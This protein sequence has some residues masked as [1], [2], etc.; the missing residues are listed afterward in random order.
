MTFKIAGIAAFPIGSYNKTHLMIPLDRVQYLLRMD[1]SV[2]EILVKLN[3]PREAAS[4][5][6][7]LN[8]EFK[9]SGNTE[10]EVQ[11][12]KNISIIYGFMS[13][14]QVIYGFI[15]LIFFLL[16]STVLINTTM[17]VIFERMREIG[18]IAAMGMTGKE[19]VR[20]FFYEAVFLSIVGAF[21]GLIVGVGITLPLSAYGLDF[22]AAMQGIDIEIS[23]IIYPRLN[24]FSTIFVFFYAVVVSS[25]ASLIPSTRA[26]KIQ[27]V[28]ALRYTG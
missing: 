1:K 17:M 13:M 22:G 27:P 16:A 11:S 9:T 23:D 14:A 5:A 19:I 3:N 26:A 2:T 8:R 4:F 12:W 24:L 10:L 15:A 21:A 28:E 7:E 25:L 6:E 18:T 20:L